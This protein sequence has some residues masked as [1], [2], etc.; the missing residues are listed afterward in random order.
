MLMCCIAVK[1]NSQLNTATQSRCSFTG[2]L[3]Y[4]YYVLVE[5]ASLLYDLAVIGYTG[6]II[7]LQKPKYLRGIVVVALIRNTLRVAVDCAV[8][9]VTLIL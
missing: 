4:F 6:V 5:A 1:F 7:Q 2:K 3:K 8:V 9:I